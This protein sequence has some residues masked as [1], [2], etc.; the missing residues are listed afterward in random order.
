M[1]VCVY[2]HVLTCTSFT[3]VCINI[4][5]SV[6]L[7]QPSLLN[8]QHTN[9]IPRHVLAYAAQA[10]QDQGVWEQLTHTYNVH[11]YMYVHVHVYM[12]VHVH[13]HVWYQTGRIWT[14]N[15]PEMEVTSNKNYLEQ[16]FEKHGVCVL[17]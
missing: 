3:A 8:M 1:C 4:I 17:H 13:V 12:Y 16:E 9:L 2:L 14:R 11:V 10:A 5:Y 7:S 15:W 6:Y